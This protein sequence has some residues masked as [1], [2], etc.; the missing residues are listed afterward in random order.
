MGRDDE[1]RVLDDVLEAV[2]AGESRALVVH[3]EPGIGKSALLQALVNKAG[4]LRILATVGMPSEAEL[5]YAGLH[6]LFGTMTDRIDRLP[7]PQRNA[8]RVAFGLQ[9]GDSP[10]RYV[11]SLGVLGLLADLSREC[12]VLCVVDDEQW[13]DRETVLTLTFVARRMKSEAAA[14]VF[15]SREGR[16]EFQG[17]PTLVLTGI[18]ARHARELL[19][20]VMAGPLDPSVR[21]QIVTETHGNPLALLDVARGVGPAEL[22]GGFRFPGAVPLSPQVE[23]GYRQRLDAL[24]P[25]ARQFL[26]LAAADPVGD[27]T[28]LWS[29]ADRLGLE[30]S[31][32]TPA[33]ASGLIS[34]GARVEFRDPLARSAVYRAAGLVARREVHEALAAVTDPSSDPDRRAWH[35]AHAADSPDEDTAV[36]LEQSAG[37]ARA[38][39][40]LAAAAAFL[41]RA[42]ELTADPSTRTRRLIAAAEATRDAGGHEAALFLLDTASM[43][44]LA[45]EQA[46]RVMRIRGIIAIEQHR[47]ADG[48]ELLLGAAARFGPDHAE[49]ARATALEALAGTFW[50]ARQN[51]PLFAKAAASVADIVRRS[52]DPSTFTDLLLEGLYVRIVD[53][54]VA[55]VPLLRRAVDLL[56]TAA[57]TDRWPVFGVNRL[58]L[59]LAEELWDEEAMG[60]LATRQVVVCRRDGALAAL[61][62]ALNY[63][64]FH[65]MHEGDFLAAGALIEESLAV[66]AVSTGRTNRHVEVVLSAWRGDEIRTPKLSAEVRQQVLD[67]R[68]TFGFCA[69]YAD[70]VLSNA[71]GRFD[72]ALEA[73]KRAFDSDQRI[74]AS[75]VVSEIIDAASR[76]G[77]LNELRSIR[78]WLAERV[79]A[80]PRAW[81]FGLHERCLAL[82]RD[83]D[84]A[85]DHYLESIAQLSTTRGQLEIARSQLLFGEWLRRKGRRGDARRYLRK[86]HQT[87][88]ALGSVGFA[89]RAARELQ[90]T[91]DVT[92]R[93]AERRHPSLTAQEA[94][95][96][97]L[98]SAGLTNPEIGAR[99]FIS[100]RTVQYHLRKVFMKLDITSRAQLTQA[101]PPEAA[102]L[103]V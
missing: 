47:R 84:R 31:A 58:L 53:G 40:G 74:V 29:A 96:A 65:R 82:L 100:R 89:G 7:V 62:Q 38:R 80:T 41:E 11:V 35:R 51:D 14:V 68:A 39:G 34:L 22:A 6:Q 101:L 91:G 37:H 67:G 21:R 76:T 2:R 17:L 98:A 45:D 88:H 19:D 48:V 5:P 16:E 27:P 59:M 49:E 92:T 25:A 3:G 90:A 15:A 55:A 43:R 64:A 56:V 71:L 73:G 8:L 44:P 54:F 12:P 46:A 13:M 30:L 93:A 70:A 75:M 86:A 87:F 61:Q 102:A 77:D 18:S 81:N 42:A 66:A 78:D 85:E 63:S 1:C 97:A 32:V 57:P 52:G 103:P 60:V 23:R 95:I 94:Q 99:L 10:D 28:T 83:D 9:E 79:A 4:D 69:D 20:S 33:L 36:E 72:V 24:P 26:L 50:D